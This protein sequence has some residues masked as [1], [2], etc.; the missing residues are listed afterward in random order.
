MFG[1]GILDLILG[2]VFIYFIMSLISSAVREMAANALDLRYAHLRDWFENIFQKDS[3]GDE[4]MNHHL[5][6]GL[7][8]KS[9]KPSYIPDNIFS[10]VVFDL[11]H[12]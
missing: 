9:K 4:I 11:F 5:I 2:L 1:S 3:F 10:T 7:T 12:A 8:T 6:A